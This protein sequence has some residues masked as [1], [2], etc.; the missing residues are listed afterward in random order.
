MK[1][2]EETTLYRPVL[3]E[4]WQMAWRQKLLWIYGFFATVTVSGGVY[5]IILRGWDNALGAEIRRRLPADIVIEPFKNLVATT[6]TENIRSLPPAVVGAALLALLLLAAI[7]WISVTSQGALIAGAATF[8]KRLVD[9]KTLFHAGLKHFWPVLAAD[10]VGRVL[11]GLLVLIPAWSVG[12]L[13][14]DP[15]GQNVAV[16]IIAFLVAIPLSLLVTMLTIY[17]ATAVVVHGDGLTAAFQTAWRTFARHWLVSLEMAGIL[18]VID[19]AAALVVALVSII[20]GAAFLFLAQAATTVGSTLAVTAAGILIGAILIVF[21][22]V[23]GAA[24]TTFRYGCWTRLYLRLE[25]RGG[26]AK[27]LRFLRAIPEWLHVK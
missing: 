15:T 11:I 21:L 20:L 18:F 8:R 9:L 19:A 26:L 16:Y 2:K 12:R 14:T 5:D 10:V 24:L 17:T 1:H 23:F 25:E 27:I 7:V 4:A 22:V 13:L 3:A 6:L